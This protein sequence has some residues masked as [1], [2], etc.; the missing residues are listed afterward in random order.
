M[1]GDVVNCN[2]KGAN[3]AKREIGE[4]VGQGRN[5]GRKAIGQGRKCI[6]MYS[7]RKAIGQGI[8]RGRSGR[9]RCRSH[10]HGKRIM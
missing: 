5:R 9:E 10:I 7:W 1:V 3:R 8:N 4:E 2:R 6:D